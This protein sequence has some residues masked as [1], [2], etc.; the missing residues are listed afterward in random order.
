MKIMGAHKTNWF[1][2]YGMPDQRLSLSFPAIKVK[3]KLKKPGLLGIRR[4]VDMQWTG[5]DSGL[6]I[7]DRL[8]SDVSLK[9]PIMNTGGDVEI[10][11]ERP[12][13]CWIIRTSL[14]PSEELWHCYQAIA[15][16]LL[17]EWPT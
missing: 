17:A 11:A 13:G 14:E 7:I 1:M 4:V 15:I 2:R 9:S 6:G 12:Y 8:N 5:E 3:P 10:R 16:H